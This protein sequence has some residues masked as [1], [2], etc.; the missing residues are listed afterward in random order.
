MPKIRALMEIQQG[1]DSR[2][3]PGSWHREGPRVLVGRETNSQRKAA[4]TM[5]TVREARTC[6]CVSM[7]VFMPVCT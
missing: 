4:E 3:Q 7:H 6:P 2:D 5:C 1:S